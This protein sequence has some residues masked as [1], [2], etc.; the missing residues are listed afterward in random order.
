MTDFHLYHFIV[1]VILAVVSWKLPRQWQMD[2]VAL[3]SN[4]FI[5][6]I[7]PVS[8]VC[9]FSSA[10]LVYL[11][12]QSKINHR[13]WIFSGAAYCIGQFLLVQYLKIY[14]AEK[15]K[16]LAILGIAYFTCR[17]IHYLIE[18][19]KGNIKVDLRQFWH[20]QSFLPVMIT[21]PINR[22]PEFIREIQRRRWDE[23]QISIAIERIIYG[24]ANVVIVGNYLIAQ[25]FSA[26]I[27]IFESNRIIF[28]W[29][30][31][32]QNWTYL[33]AQ[34]S[35]WSSIAIGFS[36]VMGI[37]I[38]ENF[39]YPFF[40]SNLIEFWQ[41]W[42][43]SLSSWAKDYV[44]MPIIAITRQ[45][46]IAIIAAMVAIGIWHELSTYYLVWGLYHAIGIACCRIFQNYSSPIKPFINF[47]L[48]SLIGWFLTVN[49][50]IC[51]Q[52]IIT[53]IDRWIHLYV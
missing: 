23:Q 24:Y 21:G 13:I 45:P 43:I 6:W 15:F 1:L 37:R 53:T 26:Q 3:L 20:Y 41:R 7:S 31:S 35:G 25:K 18:V 10:A 50:I 5:C 17:H 33:Y 11:I 38:S 22:Y 52:P 8:A 16:D 44:F 28:T 46:S 14:E 34:F 39:N 29:F 42:H 9:L 40:A 48:R 51:G 30:K 36:L 19:Y 12:S 2:G 49:Y 47:R 27:E 4:I 32:L